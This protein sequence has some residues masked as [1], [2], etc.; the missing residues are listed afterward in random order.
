MP[1]L[2][3]A[4]KV[5]NMQ[6]TNTSHSNMYNAD[7]VAMF[8]LLEK[9]LHAKDAYKLVKGRDDIS[10]VSQSRL[11]AKYKQWSLT[12]PQMQKLAHHAIKD[13]LKLQPL[14]VSKLDAQGNEVIE[15]IYPSHTNRIAAAAM[16]ADRV[17][18]VVRQNLNV[19]ANIDI[20]PVNLDNY[21]NR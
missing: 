6:N 1:T 16:V 11:R 4:K 17:D 13:T 10:I 2:D 9:G 7:T 19:N 8:K 18:P 5:N 15:K 3:Q 21:R 12:S 14:V 20:S